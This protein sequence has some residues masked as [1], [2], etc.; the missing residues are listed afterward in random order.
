MQDIL[1]IAFGLA[2]AEFLGTDKTPIGFDV[3]GHGR[4][5][6][7]APDVDLSR[8]VGWFT[9][10]YPV[11]LTVGGMSWAQVVAGEAALGPVVKDAKEQLRALPDPLTYG[12]LRYLN[13]DVDLGGADPTIGFN[14]LGRLGAGAGDLSD[15]LWRISP[16]SLSTTDVALAVPMP[17]AHTVEL[18]AGTADTDAGPQLQANW[19]WATSALDDDQI[20]RLSRLWFDALA[21]ICAHVRLGGGGLTPSDLA[22]ARL[23]Q[24]QIDEL[25][26]QHRFADVLPLTPLQ[27]GLLFQAAF[28]E[29]S[30]DDV[31]AVQLSIT[32]TGALDADR[33]RDAVHAMVGRHPNLAARFVSE[34]FDEP[35]QIIPANP[36]IAWQYVELNAD[37]D[38]DAQIETI[39][40]A[41]RAAVCE[42]SGEQP[43]FRAA[44]MRTP[45]NQY[46]L[47]VSIHHIVIDGWSLPVLLQDIFAGYF[48]HRLPAPASYRNFV[49]WLADQ[50]RDAARAAWRTVLDGFET[51]TL[52]APPTQAGPRGVESYRLSAEITTALG[53][54]AR[55]QH[56]TANTVLQ[57]AWA[58]LLMWLTG[59]QDVAFGT[60]VSG[61]PVDLPGADSMVGL[62]INT[63]PVRANMTAAITVAD[64]LDQLQG[65]HND[66]LDHEHLA[67]AEIH[68]A[69]GHDQLF[70]TLLVYENYPIDPG[71]LLGV[72]DFAVTDFSSREYNHYPLSVVATPGHELILRVEYDTEMFEAAEVETLISRLT[73]VLAAMVADPDRCSCRP[74]ICSVPASATSSTS[75][76]TG[77]C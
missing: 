27:Q 30:S 3:E 61:R 16:D 77:R 33:L 28:V 72:Q 7:L 34:Q 42:L 12:L 23:N 71:A 37:T 38:V 5:E 17:L 54:L 47:L 40:A 14:Y 9:T 48:G 44:L 25:A 46:R 52:V 49:T 4:H 11:S 55:A 76:A 59:H 21:G 20:D 39:S 69:T 63:V 6:E 68:R 10:K 51:P 65:S 62:L 1:L 18:N 43:L 56:T 57:A 2:W 58:Q 53:E 60:A 35:I 66:T 64:L 19:T 32:M 67:L 36:E 22:P 74:S 26:K 45:E 31:Y 50:D 75:G 8:T 24:K 29:G 13:P 15:D 41:E 70:D 73:Q